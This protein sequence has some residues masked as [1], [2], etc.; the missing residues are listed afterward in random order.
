[1]GTLGKKWESALP[2][3]SV[4]SRGDAMSR[5]RLI[6]L[7]ALLGLVVFA[8]PGSAAPQ[9]IRAGGTVAVT[10]SQGNWH[11][12]VNGQPYTVKGLTWGPPVSEAASRMPDLRDMG[13]NTIRTWG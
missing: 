8:P 4:G 10:G 3:S 1:M 12:T 9:G 2:R 6:A 7:L 13:V 11:L 5:F